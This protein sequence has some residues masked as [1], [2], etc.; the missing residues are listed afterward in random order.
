[1]SHGHGHS[2]KFFLTRF[3]KVPSEL[4]QPNT[5]MASLMVFSKASLPYLSTSA[6]FFSPWVRHPAPPIQPPIQAIPSI[7]LASSIP[8][9]FLRRASLQASIPSHEQG[10]KR[11]S[12]SSPCSRRA[13]ATA[14]E[15]PPL[16]AKI[17]P[18]YACCGNRS[19]LGRSNC[20]YQQSS[21]HKSKS[22]YIS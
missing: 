5:L 3:R 11:K 1:M 21:Q 10:F 19:R 18:K 13:S 15:R 12:S 6:L 7:K 14:S 2:S 20:E 9:L 8:F 16:R 17:L 4:N 22:A